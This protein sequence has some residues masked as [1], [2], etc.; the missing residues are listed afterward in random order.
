MPARLDA[1]DRKILK[2]LQ[3]DGRL[4]N[5]ELARRVGVSPP[6]CLRRVRPCPA[7]T[8]TT[9]QSSSS[10]SSCDSVRSSPEAIFCAIAN[11]GLVSPLSTWESIGALTPLRSARSRRERSMASRRLLT[12]APTLPSAEIAGSPSGLVWVAF[13]T[14]AYAIT[15]ARMRRFFLRFS[16]VDP[17]AS[18]H[19]GTYCVG[20]T[21]TGGP[22]WRRVRHVIRTA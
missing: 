5:V 9:W 20:P 13:A 17:D 11:V 14:A 21:R 4:T 3:D 16:V 15:Y 10:L 7:R 22:A 1:I 18:A 8:T 2:E 19:R 12:R 6:P